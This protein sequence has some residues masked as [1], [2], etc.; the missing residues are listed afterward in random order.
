MTARPRSADATARVDSGAIRV[1][2]DVSSCMGA[3]E[4]RRLKSCELPI[5]SRALRALTSPAKPSDARR[6]REEQPML[7]VMAA[8]FETRQLGWDYGHSRCT[9]LA[10]LPN[11][12][13]GQRKRSRE[14]S[15]SRSSFGAGSWGDDRNPSIHHRVFH[16]G[17]E[18][19]GGHVHLTEAPGFGR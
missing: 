10:C 14:V 6:D 4:A 8:A 13:T 5:R 18:H 1:C 9:P 7:R 15:S 12:C 17:A 3:I 16:G 11:G 19:R 2:V